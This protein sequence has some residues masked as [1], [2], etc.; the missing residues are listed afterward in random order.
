MP[1]AR[2]FPAVALTLLSS[3]ARRRLRLRILSRRSKL[4][5]PIPPAGGDYL[6]IVC[7]HEIGIEGLF[8]SAITIAHGCGE[9]PTAGLREI[10]NIGTAMS[11]N[12]SVGKERINDVGRN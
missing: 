1:P 9:P 8:D 10:V 2:F 12:L 4:E 7:K 3:A 5:P 11:L 6:T